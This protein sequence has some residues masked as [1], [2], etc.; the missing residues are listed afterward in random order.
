MWGAPGKEIRVTDTDK[1]GKILAWHF[2]FLFTH[3]RMVGLLCANSLI[4]CLMRQPTISFVDILAYNLERE[5]RRSN[6]VMRLN[7]PWS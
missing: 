2:S 1:S 4:D 7:A 6:S 3:A 5:I